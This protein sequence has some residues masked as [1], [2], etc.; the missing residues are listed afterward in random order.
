VTLL[1]AVMAHG[2]EAQAVGDRFAALEANDRASLV[3]F[4]SS[5]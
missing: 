3:L 1:D 2:G 4:L 5:L